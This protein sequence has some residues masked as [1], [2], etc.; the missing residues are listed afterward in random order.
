MTRSKPVRTLICR[1]DFLGEFLD[2][3]GLANAPQHQANQLARI[4]LRLDDAWLGLDDE[5]GAGEMDR[6]IERLAAVL[7]LQAEHPFDRVFAGEI[8]DPGADRRDGAFRKHVVRAGAGKVRHTR[9]RDNRPT[10]SDAM[11]IEKSDSS[12]RK[13]PNGW[14]LPGIWIGSRSQLVRSMR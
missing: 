8:I 14:T 6:D 3:R 4:E 13:K 10:L 1:A 11:Q 7:Q 5:I 2:R 9:C 12:A